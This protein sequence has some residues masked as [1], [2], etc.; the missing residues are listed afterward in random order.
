MVELQAVANCAGAGL[1]KTEVCVQEIHEAYQA[2]GTGYAQKKSPAPG[3]WGAIQRG[4][5]I[6]GNVQMPNFLQEP[7]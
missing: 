5:Q 3:A 7:G 6:R 2:V 1:E 4:A